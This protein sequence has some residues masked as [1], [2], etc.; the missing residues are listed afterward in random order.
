M[1]K[2]CPD[3]FDRPAWEAAAAAADAEAAQRALVAAWT[4]TDL[5]LRRRAADLAFGKVSSCGRRAGRGGG[6]TNKK[7]GG[8]DAAGAR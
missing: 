5:G 4:A 7:K 8:R 2:C 3:A 6:L 1:A